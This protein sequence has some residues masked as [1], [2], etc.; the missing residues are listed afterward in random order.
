MGALVGAAD[1]A[2]QLPALHAWAESATWREIVG[3]VDVRLSGGG[4]IDGKEVV[5][6]LRKLGVEAPIESH[7]KRFA[8]V[9]TDLVSGREV[10]LEF[11]LI[12]EAV[13][14]SIALPGISARR[15]STENGL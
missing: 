8:A 5:T 14:A 3:L 7:K 11:G 9:A 13:R 1:V 10:W 6:F 2:G 4:P 15:S 12:Y